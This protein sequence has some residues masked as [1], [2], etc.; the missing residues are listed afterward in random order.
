MGETLI[1]SNECRPHTAPRR[2]AIQS[3]FDTR[4]GS[5]KSANNVQSDKQQKLVSRLID[6][7]VALSMDTDGLAHNQN[8]LIHDCL[9][10]RFPYVLTVT[11]WSLPV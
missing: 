3:T 1:G 7:G 10:A 2:V 8:M 4:P 6:Q 11:Y 5:T 9:G